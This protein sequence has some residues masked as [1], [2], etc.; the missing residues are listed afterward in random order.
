MEITDCLFIGHNEIPIEGY[1]AQLAGY[2]R[3][4]EMYRE[5]NL[6][7]VTIDQKPH[8]VQDIFNRLYAGPTISP[9][10][11]TETFSNA[12][13]Y[14]GTYLTKMGFTFDYINSFRNEKPKL[15]RKLKTT[16]YRIV[17]VITTLYVSPEP[18]IEVVDFIRSID[19]EAVIVV[20]GPF[21]FHQ[22]QSLSKTAV[23][24]LFRDLIKADVYV[25][26]H[27]GESTLVDLIS[28]IQ[29]GNGLQTVPNI[30]YRKGGELKY[31]FEKRENNF[32]EENLVDWSLFA[33]G[34]CRHLHVRTSVSCPFHCSFCACPDH[35]GRYQKVNPDT[36]LSELKTIQ[37]LSGVESV[38]FIDDTLNFP[39]P[40]FKAFLNLLIREQFNIKWHSYFRCQFADEEMVSLMK[41]AG[42]TGVYLGIESGNDTILQNMNKHATVDQ[43][44]KGIKLLNQYGILAH[45]SFIVGFPGE[46]EK[47]LADTRDFIIGSG[48]DFYR[49]QLWFYDPLTPIAQRKAEFGLSGSNFKWSH[50]TMDS[51]Q[52]CDHLE[53]LFTEIND[54]LSIPTYNF[55]FHSMLH[56]NY[57]G[58]G[59]N[60]LRRLLHRFNTVIKNRLRGTEPEIL[61][62][63][64]FMAFPDDY[65]QAH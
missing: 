60:E 5:L 18:V 64:D 21:V 35:Q 62:L 56:L 25:N 47:T 49:A 13:A 3:Q 2:G 34:T 9:F 41:E 22:V 45:G 15:I 14:L 59:W 28:A 55:D 4:S 19:P 44:R 20:G 36:F 24:C 57:K 33:K 32:L 63:S 58:V 51:L 48:L 7:F 37:Q 26:S 39:V 6:N 10:S 29:S 8:T 61:S 65:I 23:N 16:S 52:A 42:C 54:P 30:F 38:Y 27:Q 43:F 11:M 12:I 53:R 31:T 46:T 17:G 40:K 1:V 50:H